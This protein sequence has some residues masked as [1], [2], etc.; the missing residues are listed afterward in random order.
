MKRV[1][2][3]VLS[4]SGLVLLAPVLIFIGVM[5]KATSPDRKSVV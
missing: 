1:L 2:D 4:L 3:I 5:V